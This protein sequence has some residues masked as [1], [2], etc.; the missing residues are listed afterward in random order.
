MKNLIKSIFVVCLSIYFMT[1]CGDENNPEGP[2][3]TNADI[4]GVWIADEVI[5][6]NCQGSNYPEYKTELFIVEQNGDNVT[7]TVIGDIEGISATISSNTVS[8]QTTDTAGDEVFITNFSGTISTDN[9]TITGSATWTWTDNNTG[10]SCSG[11]TI[12]TARKAQ[13]TVFNVNGKWQ[14]NWQSDGG[15]LQGT[16]QANIIQDNSILTGTIDIPGVFISAKDL[17]GILSGE[18]IIFGDIDDE[19]LFSG[20]IES[21]ADSASGDYSSEYL[22]DTGS[23]QAFKTSDSLDKQ[24]VVLDSVALNAN[25]TGDITFDGTDFWCLSQTDKIYRISTSSGIVDSIEVPGSYPEGLAFDGNQLLVGDGGWGLSKIFKLDLSG[26]SVFSSPG[27]GNISGLAFDGTNLWAAND[28]YSQPKI[29]KMRNNGTVIDSFNCPGDMLGGLTF[30]GNYLRLA[31]WENGTTNI[32]RIELNG[33]VIDSFEAPSFT[34]GGLTHDGTNLWYV[35]S[36]DSIAQL[37]ETGNIISKFIIPGGGTISEYD[38]TFDGTNL[39][40]VTEDLGEYKIIQISTTGTLLKTI[41]WSGNGADGLTFDGTNLILADYV[42]EKIYALNPNE[43]NLFDYPNT[44][45]INFLTTDGA[46]LWSLD[47]YNEVVTQFDFS[48]NSSGSFIT[49]MANPKGLVYDGTDL[50]IVNGFVNFEK[51]LKL[52]VSGNVLAEYTSTQYLQEPIAMTYDGTNLWYLGGSYWQGNYK[53]YKIEI[54]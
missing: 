54:Q 34:P 52:D 22:V 23:W 9:K 32:H 29:Y 16:F 49:S 37:N 8:W 1:N 13:T 38:L 17:K 19:I 39:W 26:T 42:T 15:H 18:E 25:C 27:S 33:N 51:L 36:N 6:G 28:D 50:W 35:T 12:V 30:D 31:A 41:D 3:G 11:T 21:T 45:S 47:K 4:N 2:G 53:L 24:I 40:L 14:G 20:L 10:Y 46:T 43:G 48:G 7:F 5:N 44:N